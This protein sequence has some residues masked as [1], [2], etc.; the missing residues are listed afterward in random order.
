MSITT[1]TSSFT[2]TI[3]ITK[4]VFWWRPKTFNR[5]IKVHQ[6][7][8]QSKQTVQTPSYTWYRERDH[9]NPL[10]NVWRPW[11]DSHTAISWSLDFQSTG[12]SSPQS[13]NTGFYRAGK[14]HPGHLRGTCIFSVQLWKWDEL[15]IN[16]QLQTAIRSVNVYFYS[17]ML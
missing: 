5:E 3:N 15:L 12:I 4:F 7:K 2:A 11:H 6:T 13:L 9:P 14:M 10:C 1:S 8:N 16:E 17:K